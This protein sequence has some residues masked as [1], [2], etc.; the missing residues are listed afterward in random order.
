VTGGTWRPRPIPGPEV[1]DLRHSATPSSAFRGMTELDEPALA[2]SNS[3]AVAGTHAAG[4][5]A[6]LAN[7]MHLGLRLPHVWYRARLIVEADGGEGRDLVGVT[8]PGLPMLVA[9]SNGHVAW[10]Y[11]NSYG[12]WTDLVLVDADP[13]D[14]TRYLTVD[15]VTP[16][17][18]RKETIA[19]HGDEPVEIEIKATRWGPII[20]ENDAGRLLALAWTAHDARATNIRMIDFEAAQSLDDLLTA[21]NRAG[22][23]V[24]NFVAADAQGHIAWTLMGQV[25]LR[26]N[27]DSTGPAS[28]AAPNTGWI[29]WRAPEEYPRIVDP[30][31]GRLWTANARTIDADTWMSFLGDGGYDL[32][33]RAAQIRDD[34]LQLDSATSADML[35]IQLDDR[36][37]FLTRWR[38]LLLDLLKD[39]ALAKHPQRREARVALQQWSG[40][41]ASEDSGYAIVR[42]FR[43]QARRRI[44]EALVAPVRAAHPQAR[45]VPGAQFE[46]PLWALV[47]ERPPH[48]LDP[49]YSR[50]EDALLADL[51][52][53]LDELTKECGNLASCTWGRHNT[54][55]MKHPLSDA[56]PFASSWLDMPAVPLP[57]DS[58]MPRVQGV[59]F[60]ASQR[61]VVSPGR[62]AEGYFQMPGGPVDHPLSPFYGAGHD[63]WARG[64]PTPLLPGPAA[65]KLQLAPAP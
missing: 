35:K 10:G 15:G 57:G 62:E 64:E 7:D 4:G 12:D 26:S 23:P 11:T 38:D 31:S 27:Y 44:Y 42:E 13:Q 52:A 46:A 50:W 61:L 5:H 41:A 47:T 24:Q 14:R 55:R 2:G 21:A 18:L 53:A 63:A 30:P 40:R 65:H 60:G 49:R 37:L 16:F 8:L 36:A 9:G 22:A 28:W 20:G 39:D 3:W 25:P 19:V 6:L 32:G 58:A 1:F 54:L 29:G 33:A 43:L 51:D 34:L 48:L 45:F 17:E 56:L 59:S